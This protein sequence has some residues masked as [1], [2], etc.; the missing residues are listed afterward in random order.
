MTDHASAYR[1]V[2]VRMT[3]LLLAAGP[4]DLARTV[5]ACPDWTVHDLLA[6]VVGIPEAIVGGDFPSG[7]LQAWLDGLVAERRTVPVPELCDRWAA[8]DDTLGP[9]LEGAGL[10]L[11]DVYVH[12]HDLRGALD[13][14]GARDA[15]ETAVV[16]PL[17]LANLVNDLTAAGL[18]PLAVASGDQ[19]WSSGDG[20]PGC[21]L[22]VDV[23]EAVRILA[24]RRTEAEILAAPATGD[25]GAY[26]AVIAAHSPLPAASLGERA[27]A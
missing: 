25:V 10:L 4:D 19:R 15:A 22:E 5:P 2:R 27:G 7:D 6:H 23:W 11:A 18:A 16:V 26:A 9:V 21:T 17:A 13:R 12:E 1:N 24:S 8:L 20:D 3:D 14:P